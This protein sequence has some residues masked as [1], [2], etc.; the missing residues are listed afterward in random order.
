MNQER[1]HS[2][3]LH[4]S[5]FDAEARLIKVNELFRQAH[6]ADREADQAVDQALLDLQ[7]QNRGL[8]HA[9]NLP[10]GPANDLEKELVFSLEES[11]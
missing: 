6:I 9:L 1:E 4:A 2:E 7:A 3:R 5:V 8:R 10:T 11:E